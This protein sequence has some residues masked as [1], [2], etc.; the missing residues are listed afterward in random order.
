MDLPV[1]FHAQGDARLH[2]LINAG[3]RPV[4]RWVIQNFDLS[5]VIDATEERKLLNT[6]LTR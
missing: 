3:Y 6:S 5:D 1:T 4:D 2:K